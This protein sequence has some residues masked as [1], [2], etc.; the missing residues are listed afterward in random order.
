MA[1]TS[2]LRFSCASVYSSADGS[3]TISL[4]I[5]D[6]NVEELLGEIDEDDLKEYLGRKFEP[7]DV[8]STTQ[9]EKWAEA[10]GYVK[11]GNNE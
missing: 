5:S 7:E 6:P 10:N 11:G 8:F 1:N 3:R 4:E 2:T 9:L